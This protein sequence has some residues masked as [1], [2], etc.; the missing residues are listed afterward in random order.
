M[1]N[2]AGCGKTVRVTGCVCLSVW[3][4]GGYI[5]VCES[6][7]YVVRWS[8]NNTA[9]LLRQMLTRGS[10]LSLRPSDP[11]STLSLAGVTM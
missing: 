9:V 7:S 5:V 4:K 6:V 1:E 2:S 8:V 11:C 3:L 10:T